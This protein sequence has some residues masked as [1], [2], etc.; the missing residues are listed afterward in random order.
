[1]VYQVR[2]VEESSWTPSRSDGDERAASNRQRIPRMDVAE[3]LQAFLIIVRS[4]TNVQL[5]TTIQAEQTLG[6]RAAI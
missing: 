6:T 3:R 4:Q 5:D 1:V 2:D